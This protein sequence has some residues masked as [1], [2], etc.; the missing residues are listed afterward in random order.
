MDKISELL[1]T[2]TGIDSAPGTAVAE[3]S[4]T[5]DDISDNLRRSVKKMAGED[6]Q[7]SRDHMRD[8]IAK[9]AGMMPGLVALANIAESPLLYNSAAQFFKVFADMNSSLL[10]ASAKMDK[11][12][13][14]APKDKPKEPESVPEPT[15]ALPS[16]QD[17]FTGTTAD[18]LD[19]ALEELRKRKAESNVVIDI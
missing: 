7:F 16:T 13:N 11:L 12:A 14:S 3:V 19:K 2:Q 15:A 8:A 4:K 5:F 18:F 1:G 10:E 6:Y 17:D 9:C